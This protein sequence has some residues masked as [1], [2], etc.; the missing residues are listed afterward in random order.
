MGY[1]GMNCLRIPQKTARRPSG[2]RPVRKLTR[3]KQLLEIWNKAKNKERD[4]LLWGDEVRPVHLVF[5]CSPV[6]TARQV[7]YLVVN[8]SKDSPKVVLSLR[9]ADILKALAADE[10]LA[11]KGGGVPA[12]QDP[13]QQYAGCPCP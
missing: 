4:A 5:P 2:G 12:I 6:L 10:E 9:Q 7:E 3:T 8:Y 11:A 1:Q 13:K